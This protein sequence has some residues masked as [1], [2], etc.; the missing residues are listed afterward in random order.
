MCINPYQRSTSF[1]MILETRGKYIDNES[2]FLE[3]V[4]A[5]LHKPEKAAKL[6]LEFLQDV[7]SKKSGFR[8]AISSWGRRVPGTTC[9]RA[10]P[11]RRPDLPPNVEEI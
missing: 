5:L 8:V 7:P 11:R 1:V 10:S 2:C 4:H 9:T 6:L 3:L